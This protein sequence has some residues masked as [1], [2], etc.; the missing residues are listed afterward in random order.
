MG[1]PEAAAAA[2]VSRR[3]ALP[4]L[5]TTP[6]EL[7]QLTARWTGSGQP[8]GLVPTMGS[9]HAGHL[10][11]VAA[12]Q[13]DCSKVVVSIFVNPLQFG[14]GEDYLGYPRQLEADLGLLAEQ[15]VDV[16]FCPE[17][18]TLYPEGFATKVMVDAGGELWEAE[19]RPGHFA[20]VA[21]VVTKL[22]AATGPCRAYFGEK[23]AQQAAVVSRLARDLDLGAEVSICPTVRDLDGVAL[24]SRNQLLSGPGRR[25]ARCLSQALLEAARQF[26]AGVGSGAE[27]ARAAARVIDSEPQAQRDYAGIVNPLDFQPVTVAEGGSR[28]MVAAEI[29]GVHL[30]DTS[31]LASPPRPSR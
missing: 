14:V 28:V 18:E 3:A 23:D 30:I 11:L 17:V 31:L 27:L 1:E 5:V 26:S 20:G 6:G 19:R 15:G 29:D 7:R 12:A 2:V 9:L 24:S 21:T 4:R 13:R 25:A 16:C 8:V 10:S 22:L